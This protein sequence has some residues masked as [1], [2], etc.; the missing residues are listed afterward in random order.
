MADRITTKDLDALLARIQ[1]ETG[2][3]ALEWT[4]RED[5]CGHKCDIGALFVVPGS[6]TYG[7]AWALC[8]TMDRSGVHRVVLRARTAA[9]LHAAMEAYLAGWADAKREAAP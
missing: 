4:P 5:G 8:T 9:A 2:R 1:R 7:R 3:P 6:P